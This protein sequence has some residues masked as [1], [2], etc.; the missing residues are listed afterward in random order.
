MEPEWTRAQSGTGRA[1]WERVLRPVATELAQR[2]SMMSVDVVTEIAERLTDLLPDAESFEGNR[3]SAEASIVAFAQILEAGADPAAASLAAATMAYTQEGVQRGI[4]LTMLM[5]SYRLGHAAVWERITSLIAAHAADPEQRDLA[6]ALCSQ[7]LFEYV[8]AVLCAAEEFYN[9]ERERWARSTAALRAETIAAILT[10]TPI[11]TA[12]A[13]RRL[14][15]ELSRHHTALVA[16]LAAHEEGQDTQTA[17]ETAIHDIRSQLGASALLIHPLG[18]LSAAAWIS[19]HEP[20][21]A[22]RLDGARLDTAR[23]PGVRIAIGSPA[24][25]IAGFRQSYTEATRARRVA[26]LAARPTGTVTSYSRVA[27]T[28]ITTADLDQARAFVIRELRGL[29]ANDEATLRL[30]ATLRTY[31]EENSSRSRTAKRLGIHENTVTYR[32]RQAEEILG[33]SAEERTLE[34]RIAL[35][36]THVVNPSTDAS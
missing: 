34:L 12:I 25:G 7:W 29:T 18:I 3:A 20:I 33:R 4:P 35:S 14:G 1:T 23:A 26:E 8:D 10:N 16:W 11:D 13:S 24:P 36:L 31:L 2:A 9:A 17:L 32:I 15:Y 5:R 27:L 30:A 6:T 22:E 21:A 28:A 19:T